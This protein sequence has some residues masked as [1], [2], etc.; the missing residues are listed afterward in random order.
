MTDINKET[1][2][3]I[4][5]GV[6]FNKINIYE[7]PTKYVNSNRQKVYDNFMNFVLFY[8]IYGNL[9]TPNICKENM[10]KAN[11]SLFLGINDNIK[12]VYNHSITSDSKIPISPSIHLI[13][14]EI[15]NP[16][17]TLSLLSTFRSNSNYEINNFILLYFNN[18]ISEIARNIFLCLQ[19][20]KK[21]N[22]NLLKW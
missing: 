9:N 11:G 18:I 4:N 3:L 8:L 6:L 2:K 17:I 10:E 14:G 20:N 15:K 16:K 19:K 21:M 7:M 13:Y 12:L 1:K 5:E 22:R